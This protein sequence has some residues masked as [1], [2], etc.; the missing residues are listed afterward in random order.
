M[1][2]EK[3]IKI[4]QSG[5]KPINKML[6]ANKTLNF[7][8][9]KKYLSI[10]FHNFDYKPETNHI[11]LLIK[12]IIN[13]YFNLQTNYLCKKMFEAESLRNWY[14]TIILFREHY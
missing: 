11:I 12:S 6:V 7:F 8:V 1:Q 2:T 9:S 14:K 10:K 5:N 3:N 13:L 4:Y